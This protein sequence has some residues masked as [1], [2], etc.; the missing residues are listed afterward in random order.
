MSEENKAVVRRLI[1]EVWNKGNFE[2]ADEIL[3]PD[4]VANS[5]PPGIP[6]DGEG[7]K[8][9]IGM[10]R[11]AF[12]DV[13][14]HIEDQIAEG[15]MVVTRFTAHGTHQGELMGIPPTN[16]QITVTGIGISRIV[17]GRSREEWNNYDQYGMLVQLGVIPAPGE[18]GG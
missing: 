4:F 1:E 15:D 9:F 18:G 17:E 12:P 13:H 3:A 16:K 7:F 14:L 8:Q 10:Y 2:V 6:P 5:V 11:A